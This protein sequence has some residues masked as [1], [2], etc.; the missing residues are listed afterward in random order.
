MDTSLLSLAET[1]MLIQGLECLSREVQASGAG[2]KEVKKALEEIAALKLRLETGYLCEAGAEE[3]C[4]STRLGV[5][6]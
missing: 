2:P 1:K 6:W 4:A 3:I 5:F